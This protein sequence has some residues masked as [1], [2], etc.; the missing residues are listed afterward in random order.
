MWHSGTFGLKGFESDWWCACFAD[1]CGIGLIKCRR[2]HSRDGFLI[3]AKMATLIEVCSVHMAISRKLSIASPIV[4]LYMW[5]LVPFQHYFIQFHTISFFVR[6]SAVVTSSLLGLGTDY[7]WIHEIIMLLLRAYKACPKPWIHSR[8]RFIMRDKAHRKLIAWTTSI[9]ARLWDCP[10]RRSPSAWS[11]GRRLHWQ[12]PTCNR[13]P[14]ARICEAQCR[15][16]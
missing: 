12:G 7:I 16:F 14:R 6:K 13:R 3:W 10:G 4:V 8:V 9:L 2:N 5:T 15:I 11:L 1:P